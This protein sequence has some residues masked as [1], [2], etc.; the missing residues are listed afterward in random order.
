MMV[1]DA[2][3][4]TLNDP[5]IYVNVRTMQAEYARYDALGSVLTALEEV[6]ANAENR[7]L[8]DFASARSG[9]RMTIGDRERGVVV[10]MRR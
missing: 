10:P 1:R 3:R 7:L 5:A 2:V 6:V 8:L 9:L 4:R